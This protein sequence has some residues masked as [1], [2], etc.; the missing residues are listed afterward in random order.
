[1]LCLEIPLS[2]VGLDLARRIIQGSRFH[3]G[4][5]SPPSPFLLPCP[6]F[7]M[8]LVTY[9]LYCTTVADPEIVE[10]G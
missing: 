9:V 4:L 8:V 2:E 5:L 10:R 7:S 1:M 6:P 3:C